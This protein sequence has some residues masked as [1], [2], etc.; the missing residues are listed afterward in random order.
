MKTIRKVGEVLRQFT[1]ET[2]E[3]SLTG[4]AR[5][6]GASPSGTF[7]IVDG[8][9]Q[10]GLLTRVGRGRYRL[11]P[12]VAA[13]NAVLE[14]TAPVAQAGRA[15]MDRLA[16][17]Y[18]ETIHL[19]QE[20]DGKLLIL[21]SRTGRRTLTVSPDVLTPHA[22]LQDSAPGCLHLAMMAPAHRDAVWA[23]AG[24]APVSRPAEEVL[25]RMRRDGY[26]AGPLAS[27]EDVSMTAAAIYNHAG[28]GAGVISLAVPTSRHAKEPRAFRSVT[29]RA[30][31]DISAALG[32]A[33]G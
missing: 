4:L 23:R 33:A 29:L 24:V 32:Y 7:D 19:T 16:A 2:P 3:H 8:L 9:T 5:A 22:P 20:D 10:V 30:A 21:G 15:V 27:D 11:G 1:A 18:R 25:S 13:L 17:E 26:A 31:A 12:L 28:L 14:D 6:I